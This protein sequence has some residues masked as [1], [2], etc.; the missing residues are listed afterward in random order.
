[1]S[2]IF[3]FLAA[4]LLATFAHAGPPFI[5]DDPEPV[6][7]QRWEVNYG[8]TG[9]HNKIATVAFL[10][11]VDMNYG[12]SPGVQLHL[13]PQLGYASQ[14]GVRSYGLGDTEMGLKYRLTP[15]SQYPADWMIGL[16]PLVEVPTGNASRNLGAG[17]FSQYVPIWFQTS[18][19]GWTLYGGGGYW[20]N[21]G[22]DTK[23]AW[24]GGWV[25][26]YQFT[27]RLQFG[28]EVFGK[29]ADMAGSRGALSFNLGGIYQMEKSYALLFSSGRG[30]MNVANN[31]QASVYVALQALY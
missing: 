26:L 17:A 9:T 24:A 27:E 20:F 15:E 3:S 4:T 12:I 7:Y 1:V 14:A 6:E 5:T 10:P 21:H 2:K 23:N 19:S 30:L 13:Q 11:Q 16:Y 22:P 25:A 29:T 18:R 8:L 28:G 31:N